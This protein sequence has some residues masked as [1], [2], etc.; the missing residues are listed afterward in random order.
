MPPLDGHNATNEFNPSI[1]SY[2]GIFNISLHAASSRI[3]SRIIA[4]TKQLPEF[5]YN[6]DISGIDT[7]L[8]IGWVQSSMHGGTRVSS[9]TSYLAAA[10]GRPNLT[11]LINAMVT[12]LL[13]TGG[14]GGLESFRRVQFTDSRT[15]SG[16]FILL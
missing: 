4:T 12:K 14:S 3:D 6:E 11:V 7:M 8:G 10:S 15:E 2:T 13:P 9:S 5:P 16:R 1:H